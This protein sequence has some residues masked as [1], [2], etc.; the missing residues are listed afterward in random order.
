M[1]AVEDKVAGAFRL[2]RAGQERAAESLLRECQAG[3][4]A[5]LARV[6][7]SRKKDGSPDSPAG[8]ITFQT[9]CQVIAHELGLPDWAGLVAH[10]AGMEAERGCRDSLDD[11]L[12]TLHIRCG[13]D[14]KMRLDQAGFAGDFLEYSNPFCVGP[15]TG[16]P[17][18]PEQIMARADFLASILKD[19]AL[20]PP[21]GLVTRL[22]REEAD[23]AAA[24]G[25][26]ERIVLWFEHDGYDQLILARLL[27]FFRDHPPPLLELV[28]VNHFPGSIR[29][30]GLGQLPPEALR[31][32]WHGRKAVSDAELSYGKRVWQAV[33]SATPLDLATIIQAP[34]V[35]LPDMRRAMH[36]H[37]QE[38]PSCENGLSLTE[39]LILDMLSEGNQRLG[40]LFGR[41]MMERDPLPWQSDLLFAYVIDGLCGAGDPAIR[42]DRAENDHRFKDQLSLTDTGRAV[43]E[44]RRD[45]LRCS[46]ARRWVGGV[47]IGTLP[48]WRW[49]GPGQQAVKG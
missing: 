28:S 19:K 1:P 22:T 37:L 39:Q 20:Y 31:L 30:I 32:L 24:V 18:Q 34:D 46:P 36:R 13:S 5:A 2:D 40:A 38:L 29:F 21:A 45:W 12:R 48:C 47:A 23:L 4:G 11:S 41:L 8:T 49:D 42:V 33:K 43:L 17:D 44:G 15:V 25:S 7:A 3:D 27:A 14:I 9:A 26:Y 10:I 35:P 6:M 16:D